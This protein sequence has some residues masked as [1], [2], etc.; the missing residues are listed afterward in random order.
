MSRGWEVLAAIGTWLLLMLWWFGFLYAALGEIKWLALGM[1]A[2]AAV[3]GVV[4][5]VREERRRSFDSPRNRLAQ[6]DSAHS[7]ESAVKR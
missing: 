5:A 7:A 3:A 4:L 6:A 1:L 2:V